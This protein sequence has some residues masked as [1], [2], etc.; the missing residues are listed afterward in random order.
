[1]LSVRVGE[2]QLVILAWGL[3]W[4][5]RESINLSGFVEAGVLFIRSLFIIFE[6]LFY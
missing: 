3:T 2:G 1:M 5:F 4:L 6:Y